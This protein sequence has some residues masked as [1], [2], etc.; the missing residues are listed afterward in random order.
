M[1]Y[2]QVFVV[3]PSSSSIAGRFDWSEDIN[4]RRYLRL[5]MLGLIL[6]CNA[7]ARETEK[8]EVRGVG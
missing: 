1:P 6:A 8:K 2:E 5:W 4:Y 3:T 7:S